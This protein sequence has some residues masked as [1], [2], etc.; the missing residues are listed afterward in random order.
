MGR[1]LTSASRIEQLDKPRQYKLV[2]NE[3]Y[4]DDNGHIY[5]AWRGFQTD[6]FTWL[7]SNEWDIRC[8]HQHDVGCQYHQVVKVC[9]TEHQLKRMDLLYQHKDKWVCRDIPTIFLRVVDV[10]GHEINNLFYRMLK[11]ADCPETPK[12]IQYLYRAG[13]SFNLNWFRTGKT[14]I[15]LKLLYK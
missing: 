2:D 6:N 10:T 4:L 7:N 11:N 12:Y 15:D 14:K 13:V 8:S 5:L 9:L 3:L 1:F